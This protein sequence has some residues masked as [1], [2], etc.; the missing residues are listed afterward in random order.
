MLNDLVDSSDL[1]YP[2]ILRPNGQKQRDSTHNLG[3]NDDPFVGQEEY[4]KGWGV[5]GSK[6]RERC[7]DG[8]VK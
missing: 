4:R 2:E 5:K 1:E 3:D 7:R 8:K 6:A